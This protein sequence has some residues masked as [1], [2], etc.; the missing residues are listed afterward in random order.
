MRVL[1]KAS[2]CLVFAAALCTLAVQLRAQ[3]VRPPQ[4]P[5]TAIVIF[6]TGTGIVG[7]DDRMVVTEGGVVTGVVCS[8]PSVPG[9]AVQS[10]LDEATV[11]ELRALLAQASR[12]KGTQTRGAGS[13]S[14]KVVQK[15]SSTLV[16]WRHGGGP[17]E[18]QKLQLFLSDLMGRLFRTLGPDWKCPFY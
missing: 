18:F 12:V 11:R 5:E 4:V 1:R 6:R 8:A 17:E 14:Y 10:Q 9:S 16:E 7:Q 13:F 2:G 3:A 15:S